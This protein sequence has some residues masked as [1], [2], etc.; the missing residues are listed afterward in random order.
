MRRTLLIAV[1]A[2]TVAAIATSV[3]AGW[4]DDGMSPSMSRPTATPVP[5]GTVFPPSPR[6]RLTRDIARARVALAPF[7]TS[8]PAARAA[9]SSRQIT[10]MIPNLGFH[11][12]APG[13][14]GSRLRHP[15]ILV[16]IH[17]G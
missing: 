16:Y 12:M 14:P 3:S 5:E 7:A 6:E 15:P 2:A 17:H 13:L 1:L 11:Y 4:A 8:L 10:P 9:G